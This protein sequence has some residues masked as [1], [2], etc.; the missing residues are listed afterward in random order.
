[1]IPGVSIETL[2]AAHAAVSPV[3]IAIGVVAL[4][5]LAAGRWL[6]GWQVAFLTSTAATSI[7]GFLLPFSGVTSPSPS[8][9]ASMVLLG[10]AAAA[11]PARASHRLCCVGRPGVLSQSR[12]PGGAILPERSP[13]SS[14]S[15][16]HRA[17]PLS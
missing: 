8:P 6:P 2:L 9:L 15:R 4:S 13:P 11:L 10:I 3:G 5:T 7:T 16:R 14:R 1:M 12:G 17:G